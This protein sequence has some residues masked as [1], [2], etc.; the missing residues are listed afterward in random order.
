MTWRL[1]D[2]ERRKYQL[3]EE[4]GLIEKLEKCGWAGLPAKDTGRIGGRLHRMERA[5][6]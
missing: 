6:K 2:E 4:L 5:E 3:A 1:T